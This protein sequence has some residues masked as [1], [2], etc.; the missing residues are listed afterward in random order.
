MKCPLCNNQM[1]TV[2]EDIQGCK[3]CHYEET[4]SDIYEDLYYYIS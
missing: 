4:E 1:E 2:K 3:S